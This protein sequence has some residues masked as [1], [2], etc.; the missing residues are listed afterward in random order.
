MRILMIILAL[1]ST[2]AA[3]GPPIAPRYPVRPVAVHQ[4]TQPQDA[5]GFSW[6]GTGGSAFALCYRG[7][8]IGWLDAGRWYYPVVFR[9]GQG[10]FGPASECPVEIPGRV[11]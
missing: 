9:R 3:A 7:R 6:E 10:Y 8:Q 1:T 2:A 5:S 11:K 4:S